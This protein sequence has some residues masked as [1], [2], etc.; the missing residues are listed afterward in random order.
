MF[1]GIEFL[2]V[3]IK[4]VC[5]KLYWIFFWIELFLGKWW[6]VLFDFKFDLVI[7]VLILN[8]LFVKLYWRFL[9]VFVDCFWF[10]KKD[11]E[12][13]M[14]FWKLEFKVFDVNFLFGVRFFCLGFGLFVFNYF[15][16]VV[17]LYNGVLEWG[18]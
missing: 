1:N 13:F 4:L 11:N 14:V 15:L 2:E 12:V 3:L 17:C 10:F 6:D 18:K 7:F 5:F 9:I 8:G 16:L